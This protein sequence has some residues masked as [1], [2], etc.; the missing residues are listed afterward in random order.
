[1]IFQDPTALLN[2]RDE[3]PGILSGLLR[4]HRLCN[5]ARARAATGGTLWSKSVCRPPARRAT[6]TRFLR[7]PAPALIGIARA[8]AVEPQFIVADEPVSA[9]DVSIQA[10]IINLLRHPGEK[11]ADHLF[12]RMI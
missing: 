11:G 4:I 7:R 9:L 3:R 2:P 6:R 1:M 10:Q 5:L 8:P 12:I